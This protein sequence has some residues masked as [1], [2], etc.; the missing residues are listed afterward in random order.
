MN[1]RALAEIMCPYDL[2]NDMATTCQCPPFSFVLFE[3]F[4]VDLPLA[5]K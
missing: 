3:S 1:M 5:I 4:D 2:M